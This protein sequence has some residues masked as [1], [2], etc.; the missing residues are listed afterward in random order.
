M[1]R[2]LFSP[3]RGGSGGTSSTSSPSPPPPA[4][5]DNSPDSTNQPDWG[6]GES[7]E[8]VF[9]VLSRDM[10]HTSVTKPSNGGVVTRG[11]FTVQSLLSM[12]HQCGSG[13]E[14]RNN[15]TN[16]SLQPERHDV[17]VIGSP[18]QYTNTTHAFKS[19]VHKLLSGGSRNTSPTSGAG[20]AAGAGNNRTSSSGGKRSNR[21]SSSSSSSI[22]EAGEV[23]GVDLGSDEEQEHED[24]GGL[25]IHDLDASNGGGVI[26]SELE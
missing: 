6:E 24:A 8:S 13:A 9:V 7:A 14:V 18:Q 20:E 25:S 10:T 5:A 11:E 3:L 2:R 1:L 26:E 4:S 15:L 19:F 16:S 23:K 17:G 21:N 22:H 12:D